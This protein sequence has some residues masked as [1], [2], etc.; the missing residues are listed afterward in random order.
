LIA[1]KQSR[2]SRAAF[3]REKNR[4][5]LIKHAKIDTL[6]R[7]VAPGLPKAQSQ[8]PMFNAR[9]AL[10]VIGR[11]DFRG[12]P[13]SGAMPNHPLLTPITLI[14]VMVSCTDAVRS[15]S[16]DFQAMCAAQG[17]KDIPGIFLP[18]QDRF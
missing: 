18:R 6:P 8:L 14:A 16:L 2:P 11:E 12:A 1:F 3:P 13:A 4:P 15:Q 5:F 17:K 7:A 10:P 9:R